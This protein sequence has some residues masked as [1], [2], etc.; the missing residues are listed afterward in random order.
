MSGSCLEA[1]GKSKMIWKWHRREDLNVSEI[2]R[3]VR[4][5][6]T[7]QSRETALEESY[8]GRHLYGFQL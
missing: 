2:E 8:N 4:V 5:T 1:G 7:M 3:N 6:I